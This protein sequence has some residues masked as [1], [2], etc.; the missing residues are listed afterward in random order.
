[1]KRAMAL[2]VFAAIVFVFLTAG[3][4]TAPAKPKGIEELP[5]VKLRIMPTTPSQYELLK[6]RQNTQTYDAFVAFDKEKDDKR[7]QTIVVLVQLEPGMR[8]TRTGKW[9]DYDV[10][11][12]AAVDRERKRAKAEVTMMR[13]GVRVHQQESEVVLYPTRPDG[14]VPLQ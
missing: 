6:P 4:L 5:P 1:M 14:N 9:N 10:T 3:T 7:V 12:T 8:A 2:G 13:N 11:L